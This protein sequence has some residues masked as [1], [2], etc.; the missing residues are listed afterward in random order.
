MFC[1]QI[2]FLLVNRHNGRRHSSTIE[3]LPNGDTNFAGQ[4]TNDFLM[5]TVYAGNAYRAADFGAKNR[6]TSHSIA[7]CFSLLESE[8][9]EQIHGA[10]CA[11]AVYAQRVCDTKSPK[12]NEK[13]LVRFGENDLRNRRIG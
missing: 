5:A 9:T 6:S 7:A 12:T 1:I 2:L 4:R 11:Q 8:Q 3:L 10:V 13:L